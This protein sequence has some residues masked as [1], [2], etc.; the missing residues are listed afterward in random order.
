MLN[1]VLPP[2]CE[3]EID[4]FSEVTWISHPVEA[5]VSDSSNS[6]QEVSRAEIL[7]QEIRL[8]L[9]RNHYRMACTNLAILQRFQWLVLI[10]FLLLKEGC[11]QI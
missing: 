2:L 8:S 11:P 3:L 6:G 10:W 4:E 1:T 7:P 5:V 9:I